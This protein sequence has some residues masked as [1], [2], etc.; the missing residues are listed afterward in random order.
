MRHSRRRA[1]DSSV[2]LACGSACG[3]DPSAAIGQSRQ[4]VASLRCEIFPTDLDL[5]LAF[6][7][8]ILGFDVVRD[9]RRAEHPYIAFERGDVRLG[10]AAWPAVPDRELR[11]PPAGVELV[12][13]VDDL[14]ADRARVAEAGWPIDQDLAQRPWGLSDFRVLDP[15]GYYWRLTGPVVSRPDGR[16]V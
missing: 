2:Y 8:D 12:L 10:A 15:D 14:G 3:M 13:E 16:G 1:C 6:Y 5:T 4:V 7:R 9:E 11:R